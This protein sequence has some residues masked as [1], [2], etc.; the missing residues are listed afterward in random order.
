[1]RLS[2]VVTTDGT[3]FAPIEITF[4]CIGCYFG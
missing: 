2:G 3:A 4:D 1:M